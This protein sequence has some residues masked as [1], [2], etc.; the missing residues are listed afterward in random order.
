M[1]AVKIWNTPTAEVF[2]LLP[3]SSWLLSRFIQHKCRLSLLKSMHD[4]ADNLVGSL[5]DSS[6][7]PTGPRTLQTSYSND[8]QLLPAD[9]HCILCGDIE[10]T[11]MLTVVCNNSIQAWVNTN[12]YCQWYVLILTWVLL[13]LQATVNMTVFS[14]I[15]QR[16]QC[17]PSDVAS[18]LRICMPAECKQRAFS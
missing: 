13:L 12:H 3:C 2:S 8:M 5:Q 15:G 10:S 18:H 16:I 7:W 14:T 11:V 4:I 17:C 1:W 6:K 9:C